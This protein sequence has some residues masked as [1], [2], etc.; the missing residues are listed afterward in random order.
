MKRNVE[1]HHP[2]CILRFIWKND[3][4]KQLQQLWTSDY[5]GMADEW[6]DIPVVV[7]E[8]EPTS[9][10]IEAGVRFI[11]DDRDDHTEPCTCDSYP[12]KP[13]CGRPNAAKGKE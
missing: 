13:D 11:C 5:V 9:V 10:Q 4:Q 6:R 3:A 12:H 1:H 8:E 2:T 7:M